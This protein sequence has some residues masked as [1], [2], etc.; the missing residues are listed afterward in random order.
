MTNRDET[1]TFDTLNII[2]LNVFIFLSTSLCFSA[3]AL[4]LSDCETYYHPYPI[5]IDRTIEGEHIVPPYYV[6]L[7]V[8]SIDALATQQ[9][10]PQSLHVI[11]L[12]NRD[13]LA[14]INTIMPTPEDGE[15]FELDHGA[16]II[17]NDYEVMD[18]PDIIEVMPRYTYVERKGIYKDCNYS[19]AIELDIDYVLPNSPDLGALAILY[20]GRNAE[21]ALTTQEAIWF[22]RTL[23]DMRVPLTEGTTLLHT[24]EDGEEVFSQ[25]VCISVQLMDIVGQFSERS[26]PICFDPADESSPYVETPYAQGCACSS[27]GSSRAPAHTTLLLA[28]LGLLTLLWRSNPNPSRQ[29]AS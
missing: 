25:P 26:K 11:Y 17:S 5:F 12:R 29:R 9:R 13:Y 14:L 16:L 22:A 15:R 3:D 28:A 19:D 27:I 10:I 1:P 18:P 23:G 6:I 20:A 7:S 21:E 2:L 4:S 24:Y 8:R